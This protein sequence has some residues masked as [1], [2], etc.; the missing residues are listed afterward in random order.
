VLYVNRFFTHSTIRLTMDRER[1]AVAKFMTGFGFPTPQ[2]SMVLELWYIL[3]HEFVKEITGRVLKS[4]LIK[5]R[6]TNDPFGEYDKLFDLVLGVYRTKNR[7]LFD[8]FDIQYDG[9]GEDVLSQ[10][11]IYRKCMKAKSDGG[12]DALR[13]RLKQY[14]TELLEWFGCKVTEKTM[15]K[16]FISWLQQSPQNGVE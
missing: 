16:H 13:L 15:E 9:I 12:V 14:E 11:A 1:L 4:V 7:A 2:L 5:D 6:H 3:D 8:R 10:C